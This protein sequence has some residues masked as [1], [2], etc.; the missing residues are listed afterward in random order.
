MEALVFILPPMA[1][2]L[3]W[4]WR[5]PRRGWWIALWTACALALALAHNHLGATTHWLLLAQHVGLNAMLGLGFGRTL[6]KESV[7]LVSRFA[8]IVHGTLSVKL[9]RYTRGVTWAWTIYFALTVSVSVMLFAFAPL[10]VWSVFVNLLSVPLVV[11]MFCGEYWIRTLI[12]PRSERSSLLQA[13]VAY[14]QY[15][16]NRQRQQDE[17]LQ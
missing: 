5:T 14:R 13:V 8:K 15:S 3:L 1:F 2:A 7:P 6:A 12:V 16:Q 10:P 11:A 9:L 17:P 4:A